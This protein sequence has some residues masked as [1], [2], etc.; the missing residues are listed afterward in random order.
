MPVRHFYDNCFRGLQFRE[1]NE[2][3]SIC[4]VYMCTSMVFKALGGNDIIQ[5]MSESTGK[6]LMIMQG[7]EHNKDSENWLKMKV[8]RWL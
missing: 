5:R 4:L 8:R 7:S 6:D 2:V 3:S 1:K